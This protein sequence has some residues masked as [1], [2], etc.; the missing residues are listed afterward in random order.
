MPERKP[1]DWEAI[2]REYRVDQLSVR[3]IAQKYACSEAG[4]RKRAKAEGWTRALADKVRKAVKEKLVRA[5]GAQDGAQGQRATDD[6][7]IDS[8]SFRGVEVVLSQRRDIAQ[9]DALGSIIA[10]RLSQVLEGVA[11]DGPCLGDKESVGDL[12]EKLSRIKA[13]LIP[14]QRQAF[15]L[16]ADSSLES[17]TLLHVTRIERVIVRPPDPDRGG[18]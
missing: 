13:R 15:N 2:E 4:V 12:L 18:I 16:D 6:K 3:Q 11:P 17:G 7:I 9:L 5:D 1:I 8:A 14:L 10:I